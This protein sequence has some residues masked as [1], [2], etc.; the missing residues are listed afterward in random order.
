MRQSSLSSPN[1]ENE[2]GP[3]YEQAIY[4]YNIGV[5]RG[6]RG[7][8][9]D[10][11]ASYRK[12]I[13]VYPYIPE[14]YDNLGNALRERGRLD[15]AVA[16][17]KRAIS[18]KPGH[19]GTYNNLGSALFDVGQ[20]EAAIACY[21]KAIGLKRDSPAYG[22]LANALRKQG[23]LNEAI[24]CFR[25]AISL[26]PDQ[27]EAYHNLGN[28]LQDQERLGEAVSHYRWAIVIKPGD[29][30][31]YNGLGTALR[32]M[33]RLDEAVACF[34]TALDLRPDYCPAYNNLGNTLQDQ[35]RMDDAVACYRRALALE[36]DHPGAHCN[37]A[38][39]LLGQG[40][41][42][43]GW[44]A[45]ERRWQT[46]DG[47]NARRDFG[48]PQWR[49]EAAEGKTLLIHAE[50]GFGDS[51]QFC[52]YA[53]LAAARGLRVVMEVQK[54]L[55]R[56]LRGLPG[57]EQVVPYGEPLPAFDLHCPM[58]S[59]PLA[60]G[61]TLATIPSATS[62][63]RADDDLIATWRAR[64]SA[65]PDHGRRIGLAWA[66][67]RQAVDRRRS[68]A[69]EKLAPLFDL[70][71]MQFF[72]L[73]K[74]GSPVSKDSPV[75]DFMSEMEDFA[76]TAALIANLDLVISVDTAVVHLAAAL[77]KPVW[78]ADRFS[79]CWRWLRHREDSPWYPSLRLFRQSKPRDWHAVIERIKAELFLFDNGNTNAFRD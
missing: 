23:D 6:V 38:M 67:R 78:M 56:L 64:L 4:F 11:I 24:A 44:E 13:S 19:P 49:G 20:P 61:T 34:Q 39:A 55:L 27:S 17:Y 3:D 9:S 74:D 26:Q 46:P 45:Y 72:S 37:L 75:T 70:P 18:L 58:L 22:N 66:G 71:N 12:A 76:D 52:R 36:P 21:R 35:G 54:P 77:G 53:S 41:L 32:E 14:A 51:L 69:P 40:D 50:Q 7:W 63:L 1:L 25:N 16:C 30:E 65:L 43:A 47:I 15:D 2:I 62:Y 10:A 33:E 29:P 28:V 48:R 73:Q 5:E 57:V 79:P 68:L 60:L 42:A 59:M 31:A 8:L